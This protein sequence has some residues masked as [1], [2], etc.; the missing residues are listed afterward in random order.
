MK[1]KS[2]C[3]RTGISKRNIHYYI[4]EGLLKPGQDD[5]NGY[6]DFSESDCSR[7]MMIRA[8]RHA[9]FSI[10]QIRSLL[11][12]PSTAGYYLNLRLRQLNDEI[13]RSRAVIESL[14][15]IR[16]HLPL[17]ISAVDLEKLIGEAVIPDTATS[18]ETDDISY[19]IYD[20]DLVNRFLWESFLP[21]APLNDYQ[22]YLWNKVIRFS[23]GPNAQDYR[24]LSRTLKRLSH[25]QIEKVFAGNREVHNE[26]I[27][28]A[29]DEYDDYEQKMITNIQEF[30]NDP[31][32]VREWRD[33]YAGFTAPSARLYDSE[34]A[35]TMEELSPLFASYRTKVNLV[36]G[37]V[38]EW[39]CSDEGG[40]MLNEMRHKLGMFFNID[41]CSHGEL[42]AMAMK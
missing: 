41:D 40:R 14:S 26:V 22:E 21:D 8:L 19:E 1:L 37:K 15:Y 25:E 42:Q 38:Y 39:L 36:C 34:I 17:H 7:L 16:E 10:I 29:E 6:Y 27:Y 18:P 32:R 30:L 20:N 3:E 24:I 13:A 11:N 4:K 2:V 28:L 5:T 9:G 31:P 12:K 35:G 23:N 33:R